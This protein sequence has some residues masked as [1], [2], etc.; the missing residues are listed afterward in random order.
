MAKREPSTTRTAVRRLCGQ[1][2]SGPS[3]VAAQSCSAIRLCISGPA[4]GGAYS[5]P[6]GRSAGLWG[7]LQVA[8]RVDRRAVDARLEVQVVAEA[9]PGAAD[10]AD[11]LALGDARAVGCAVARL[12][13]VA[14]R[15]AAG[16]LDAGVV[17]VAA[18]PAHQHDA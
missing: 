11:D 6:C 1:R 17:A 16:V 18:R 4:T 13:G 15:Q 12:V 3:G 5:A 14:R 9:V 2:S 7:R 8:G 10:V